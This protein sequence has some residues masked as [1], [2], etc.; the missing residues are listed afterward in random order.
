MSSSIT[1]TFIV[2]L[3][4]RCHKK[5]REFLFILKKKVSSRP[6]APCAPY[7][8]NC[9]HFHSKAFCQKIEVK[10]KPMIKMKQ[11]TS[12]D[13]G[14]WWVQLLRP[15]Q[16]EKLFWFLSFYHFGLYLVDELYLHYDL[17]REQ[18]KCVYI[19]LYI[20][21]Y[22]NCPAFDVSIILIYAKFFL[23]ISKWLFI[24]WL[25]T[26]TPLLSPVYNFFFSWS[27]ICITWFF[28]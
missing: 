19:Q 3:D 4:V 17:Y 25:T 16:I 21:I 7:L 18:V 20:F 5:K 9:L 26:K 1:S 24:P 15:L 27:F 11:K 12:A 23:S 13:Y 22:V 2:S 14:R 8:L 10:K 6:D 28:S